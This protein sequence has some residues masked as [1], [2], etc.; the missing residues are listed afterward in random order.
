MNLFLVLLAFEFSTLKGMQDFYLPVSEEIK[1]YYDWSYYL[2]FDVEL[3]IKKLFYIKGSAKIL[4]Y[5]EKDSHEFLPTA[6]SSLFEAG[7]KHDGFSIGIRHICIH[8][9]VPYLD[10]KNIML[11]TD[12]TADEIFVRYE[13][14]QDLF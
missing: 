10:N 7:I 5:K 6:L 9:I 13:I 1:N 11:F 12:Q 8:P 4:M 14:E 2:Q 3:I